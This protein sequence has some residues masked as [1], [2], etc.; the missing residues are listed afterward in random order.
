MAIKI[1]G[2]LSA[3][4]VGHVEFETANWIYPLEIQMILPI[5]PAKYTHLISGV[6]FS[7]SVNEDT[8]ECDIQFT[9]DQ[10]GNPT[11][12]AFQ[13]IRKRIAKV[14]TILLFV[15]LFSSVSMANDHVP[16]GKL[17]DSTQPVCVSLL[18]PN[19]EEVELST[20]DKIVTLFWDDDTRSYE[21][22]ALLPLSDMDA[23]LEKAEASGYRVQLVLQTPHWFLISV[24][25]DTNTEKF[26]FSFY[27]R[28]AEPWEE[29]DEK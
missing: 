28:P 6:G 4:H 15:V 7:G 21:P 11:E 17:S 14:L 12:R 18:V 8:M 23:M 10:D 26:Y 20:T 1:K 9:V 2:K 29:G 27:E 13:T 16:V 25:D 24:I 22:A 3:L 19:L 5:S